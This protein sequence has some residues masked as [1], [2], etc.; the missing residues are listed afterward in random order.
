MHIL[1]VIEVV[2]LGDK[3]QLLTFQWTLVN[4]DYT[5]SMI[6]TTDVFGPGPRGRTTSGDKLPFAPSF[7]TENLMYPWEGRS[8][9]ALG[10]INAC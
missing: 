10:N 9:V 4:F 1:E 6:S 8:G 5:M 3:R 2:R 7:Q